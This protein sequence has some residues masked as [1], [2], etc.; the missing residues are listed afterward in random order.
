[1]PA[2]Y[3]DPLTVENRA[4]IYRNL[5][6]HYKKDEHEIHISKKNVFN[7]KIAIYITDKYSDRKQVVSNLYGFLTN[8]IGNTNISI[9]DT[10]INNEIIDFAHYIAVSPYFYSKEESLDILAQELSKLEYIIKDNQS[11]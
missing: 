3:A 9:N 11:K 4:R 2:E 5:I 10:E 6:E 8:F 1:M 7:N